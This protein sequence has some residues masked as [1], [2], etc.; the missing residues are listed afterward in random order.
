MSLG[1][2]AVKNKEATKCSFTMDAQRFG[3]ETNMYEMK[4]NN[5]KDYS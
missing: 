3:R 4:K 1:N 5:E 2:F